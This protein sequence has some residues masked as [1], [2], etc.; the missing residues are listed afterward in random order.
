M[1]DTHQITRVQTVQHQYP[2]TL[3]NL[4][5]LQPLHNTSHLQNPLQVLTSDTGMQVIELLLV[6]TS[7]LYTVVATSFPLSLPP[8]KLAA[9]FPSSNLKYKSY[10]PSMLV[11]AL[12]RY[13]V[14]LINPFR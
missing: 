3:Q 4:I 12:P 11:L 10:I 13:G 2:Q 14:V 9:P 5:Y 8:Q 1:L 7:A 6:T